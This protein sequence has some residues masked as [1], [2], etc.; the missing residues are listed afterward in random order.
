MHPL[1]R[2]LA[3][4]ALAAALAVPLVPARAPAAVMAAP[5]GYRPKDFA[6][7]KKDGVY[8]L[9]YIRHNDDYPPWATEIDF[10][11]AVSTD[12]YHWVQLPPVLGLDPYGWD[13]LHVWAPHVVE[14][15]GLWWMF[16]TGVSDLPQYRDTQRIGSAVSSDLVTWN[17]VFREPVW[18]THSAPW[19]WWAPLRGGMACRD[20]FVMPDPAAPGQWLMYYTATPVNDTLST[21]VGVAR[22][23]QG[24]PAEWRDEKPLWITHWSQSYNV[25][26]ESPHL[27]EHDGRWFMFI[28]SNATQALSFFV[29]SN[30]LGEPSE[31]HYRGR[32]KNMIGEDTSQWFASEV[33]QD[34]DHDLFAF[35]AGNHIEIRRILWAVGDTFDL[36]APS[37][38][39]MVGM[40]WSHVSARENQYVGLTLRSVNGFAFDSELEAWVKDASGAEVRAP[41]DS[42]GLPSRPELPSA[43]VQLA[44]FA[45]RWP[46]SLPANQPMELR[47]AMADGTASSA[48]LPV[49]SNAVEQRPNGAPGGRTTDPPAIVQPDTGNV[50]PPPPPGDDPPRDGVV[51]HGAL[52]VLQGSPVHA[53]PVIAFELAAPA[54]VR[55]ELFDLLGRRVTTLADRTFA[56]GAH[57]LPWDGRDAAGAR[58]ARGLYFVRRTTP[59]GIDGTKLFLD[60]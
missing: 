43:E 39:H 28:T 27:F 35:A 19:A 10:G 36:V 55:V 47:V 31:W 12:L 23:P 29:G 7:V 32:L 18:A 54:P 50:S 33:L 6:F 15:N 60:R 48:W 4:L 3:S 37:M 44:W 25:S 51:A 57:V 13:N 58:V 21:L 24:E 42:L 1:L 41:M 14:W 17:R 30:P 11:H 53:G 56:A 5:I 22:S 49:Y 2:H 34:G 20:P 26:T 46:A 38:F 59:A 45:R 16:Y 8:H 9:F 52:R 40:D